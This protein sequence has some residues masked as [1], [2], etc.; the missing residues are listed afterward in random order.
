MKDPANQLLIPGSIQDWSL[1]KCRSSGEDRAPSQP[2][3]LHCVASAA[4]EHLYPS[5]DTAYPWTLVDTMESRGRQSI[6][7][8]CH[9]LAS[10]HTRKVKSS[11]KAEYHMFLHEAP[12]LFSCLT[13]TEL[14]QWGRFCRT[15][16]SLNLHI[17]LNL[18]SFFFVF[19]SASTTKHLQTFCGFFNLRVKGD[20]WWATNKTS[21]LK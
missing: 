21:K 20:P 10:C 2:S 12:F 15:F 9:L 5:L 8:C 14:H 16:R 11:C 18:K 19:L 13:I 6:A 1:L 4:V 7:G 3:D 17:C